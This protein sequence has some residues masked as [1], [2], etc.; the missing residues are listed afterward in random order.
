MNK[1]SRLLVVA[2]LMVLFAASLSAQ[3]NIVKIT[4]LPIWGKYALQYERKIAGQYSVELEWQHWDMRQKKENN[5]FLLGLL[6]TSSSSDVTRVQGNRIQV[7]GRC[8]AHDNMTGFFLEGG[9]N[10]G[11]FDVK[12]TETFSS[13]S[14]LDF[15]TGDFGSEREKITRYDNVRTKGLKA[16]IGFQKKRGN[17][18]VNFSG[19]VEVNEVDPQVAKLVRSLRDVAP[20]GR[21]TIGVGF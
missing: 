2:S 11:K 4:P 19:G 16:G 3:Q 8:Y 9:F 13:F 20:Y 15:F 1:K 6:Y 12:R 7:V 21:F 14:I 5:F 18:F 10:F 17:L